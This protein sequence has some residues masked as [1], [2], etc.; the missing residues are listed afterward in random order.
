M[1]ALLLRF[2]RML[3]KRLEHPET[4]KVTTFINGDVYI[5]H[6]DETEDDSGNSQT[7]T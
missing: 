1:K 7:T 6:V 4:K 5:I 2:L 3:C